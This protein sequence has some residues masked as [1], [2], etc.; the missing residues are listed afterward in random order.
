MV[1]SDLIYH[2]ELTFDGNL[3]SCLKDKTIKLWQTESGQMLQSIQ[4]D[5]QV[6]CAKTLN[7]DLIAVVLNIGEILIHDLNQMK[8]I[9]HCALNSRH[10]YRLNF[11]SDGSLL[12]G[13]FDGQINLWK[14]FE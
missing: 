4:F 14:I 12:T 1:E 9:K 3:L 13:H 2:L 10:I 8:T 11:L 5:Y 7:D 6:F